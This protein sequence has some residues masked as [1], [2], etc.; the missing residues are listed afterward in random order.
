M[1][2]GVFALTVLGVF[3]FILILCGVAI[4]NSDGRCHMESC[5]H[6]PYSGF[7]D[8]QEK[9]TDGRSINNECYE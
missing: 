3:S 8:E 7:C 4:A 2:E 9:K 6:C 1:L 5:D